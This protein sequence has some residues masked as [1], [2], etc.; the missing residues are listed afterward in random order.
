MLTD[1]SF[2]KFRH[3]LYRPEVWNGIVEPEEVG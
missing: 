2:G 3:I 1:H